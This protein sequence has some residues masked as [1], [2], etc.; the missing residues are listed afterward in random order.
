M[1]N[2]GTDVDR[3]KGTRG[4]NRHVVVDRGVEGGDKKGW[5]LVKIL[6][7]GD[8]TEEVLA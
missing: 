2:L 4:G 3:R 1:T 7:P 5:M 8:V 6:D